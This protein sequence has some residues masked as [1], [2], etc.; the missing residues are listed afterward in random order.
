MP[1]VIMPIGRDLGPFYEMDSVDPNRDP[2][3][4]V[5]G[6]GRTTTELTLA[7]YKVW[8]TPFTMY[9]RAGKLELTREVL[10]DGAR[11]LMGIDNPDPIIADALKYGLFAEFDIDEDTDKPLT[12]SGRQFLQRFRLIPTADAFGCSAPHSTRRA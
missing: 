2:R 9:Q 8:K 4:Y 7:E 12:P 3:E 6:L 5:I 11:A 1:V 10:R